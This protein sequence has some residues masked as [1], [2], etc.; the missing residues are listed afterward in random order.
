MGILDPTLVRN[1]LGT[2]RR[3]TDAAHPAAPAPAKP[4]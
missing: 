2:N 4:S 1:Q 3:E